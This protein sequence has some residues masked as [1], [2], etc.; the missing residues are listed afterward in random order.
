MAGHN[1]HLYSDTKP[2]F[3]QS[4]GAVTVEAGD[5]MYM[6]ENQSN[7]A[8]PFVYNIGGQTAGTAAEEHLHTNFLGVAMEGKESGVTENVTIA[9]A[10]VFRFE[11]AGKNSAVTIGASV[12]AVSPANAGGSSNQAVCNTV[13]AGTW[14]TTA[15]LGIIQKTQ[16][17]AS[18]VDVR[19]IPARGSGVSI[20]G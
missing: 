14:G 8:Y 12:S 10:G 17:G 5:L 18:F 2:I 9:T 4:P 11:I 13:A 3:V 20:S 19:I 7:Q 15:V 6:E 1:R 16:S